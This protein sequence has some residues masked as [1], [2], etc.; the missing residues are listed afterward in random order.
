MFE[1]YDIIK[2]QTIR[3]SRRKHLS[4]VG[5]SF[6]KGIVL[7][8]ELATGRK[9][10]QKV[11]LERDLPH[12]YKREVSALKA[13]KRCPYI[14][15]M[16]SNKNGGNCM[17]L[18]AWILF[19]YCDL[20]TLATLIERHKTCGK[21]IRESFVLHV[22]WSLVEALS[23]M[24][25]GEIEVGRVDRT[26]EWI[27]H[28]DMH[29][30]NIF[31]RTSK[32]RSGELDIILADFGSSQ[33]F[34]SWSDEP[35]AG[36]NGA[37]HPHYGVPDRTWNRRSDLYQV[38]LVVVSLCRLT[39]S[40][41]RVPHGRNALGSRYSGQLN[42]LVGECLRTLPEQRARA[43]QVREFLKRSGLRGD[44]KMEGLRLGH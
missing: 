4:H 20:G 36:R 10:I 9:L 44:G 40:P 3:V 28:G 34:R 24:Q 7:C 11:F 43:S 27:L 30:G 38:G 17:P 16:V 29:P 5:G 41:L 12:V 8:E 37:Q 32:K 26:H 1:C 18:Q 22:L 39:M 23:F 33:H 19:E 14:I 6:N 35:L 13:L 2:K 31:L 21:Q 25:S 42:A 15:D